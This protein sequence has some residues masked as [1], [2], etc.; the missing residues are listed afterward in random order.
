MKK[1]YLFGMLALAAMTMVGCSNDEV[2]NDYSQDNAIQFGTYVGRGASSR[3]HV[4]DT[5]TLGIE[6]FGVFAYYTEK[7]DFDASKH[8]PDFMYNQLVKNNTN[9]TENGGFAG[10]WSYD[11]LKYWPNNVDDKVT[12]LAYA[13]YNAETTIETLSGDDV[14]NTSIEYSVYNDNLANQKDLLYLCQTKDDSSAESCSTIN[15]TKQSVTDKVEFHFLHALSRIGFK[16][17]LMVDE[18]NVDDTGEEDDNLSDDGQTSA[19]NGDLDKNTVVTIQEIELIGKFYQKGIL[20]LNGGVWTAT[21]PT[22]DYN[23]TLKDTDLQNTEFKGNS[24]KNNDTDVEIR[25][26]NTDES[27]LMIIPQLFEDFSKNDET[28]V[29]KGIKIRVKYEVKTTDAD[30]E[31]NSSTI[32]NNITSDEFNIEFEQGKAYSFNL[33]LG[34]TS[35]KLSAEVQEWGDEKEIAVNVPINF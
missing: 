6:G 7:D 25:Q 27:Y 14:N 9:W 30:N 17:E 15:L 16:A 3:A 21:A 10:D 22:E 12:F 26:V 28:T 33:H 34:L 23:F 4:I 35:V 2:V 13:P 11:P 5:K 29:G 8:T 1:N 20:N 18:I 19:T 24:D 32:V 31:N